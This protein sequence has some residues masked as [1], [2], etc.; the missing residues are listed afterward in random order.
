MEMDTNKFTSYFNFNRYVQHYTNP[1]GSY[2]CGIKNADTS[3]KRKMR[4]EIA[5]QLTKMNMEKKKKK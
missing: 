4:K 1:Y 3:K 2:D 5:R